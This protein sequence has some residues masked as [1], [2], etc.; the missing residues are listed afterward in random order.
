[1]EFERQRAR[2]IAQNE[3][4]LDNLGV[5]RLP[6][7]IESV[8]RT[9]TAGTRRVTRSATKPARAAAA[10]VEAA[11]AMPS[12][13]E[14]ELRRKYREAVSLL[15]RATAAK[16]AE[17]DEQS[18][19][20]CRRECKRAAVAKMTNPEKKDQRARDAERKRA[21]R[22]KMTDSEKVYQRARRRERYAKM[23]NPEK[24]DARARNRERTRETRRQRKCQ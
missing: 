17:V 11:A 22:A 9:S 12:P 15:E 16:K 5:N 8:P 7:L 20:A 4:V 21:Y 19:R 18:R 13:D 2:N 24:E 14:L 1:M 3:R 10:E 6:E 23:T